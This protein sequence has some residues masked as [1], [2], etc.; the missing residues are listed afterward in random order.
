MNRILIILTT[1]F[2]TVIFGCQSSNSPIAPA[3]PA[4][5]DGML[6]H[7]EHPG[8]GIGRLPG[9]LREWRAEQGALPPLQ[10]PHGAGLG[11]LRVHARG[12]AA[13]TQARLGRR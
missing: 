13:K 3:P 9:H 12:A 4:G 7:L 1:A 8:R 2:L 5:A 6:R 11:R 10:D